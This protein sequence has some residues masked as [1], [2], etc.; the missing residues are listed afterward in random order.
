MK[1]FHRRVTISKS[2]I[3]VKH[4]KVSCFKICQLIDTEV[5]TPATRIYWTYTTAA[6][7]LTPLD[8]SMHLG[9]RWSCD[10][11]TYSASTVDLYCHAA[12]WPQTCCH[13]VRFTPLS[14]NQNYHTVLLLVYIGQEE[15][16]V[17]SGLQ[18]RNTR[19]PVWRPNHRADLGADLAGWESGGLIVTVCVALPVNQACL[20]Q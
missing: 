12:L 10:T 4:K 8:S 2:D 3:W 17:G 18:T 6:V 14:F 1:A 9:S 19:D 13:L 5:R 15:H 7:V 11:N 16:K 20:A